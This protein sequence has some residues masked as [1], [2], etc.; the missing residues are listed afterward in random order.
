MKIQKRK[1]A[2]IWNAVLFIF[3]IAGLVI[4]LLGMGIGEMF[5]YYTQDSNIFSMCVSG[6]YLLF[7]NKDIPGW[8]NRLRYAASVS[9]M[10]TFTVVVFVL[11]PMYGVVWYPW[12]FF[13]GANFFYHLSCPLLSFISFVLFEGGEKP[14]VPDTLI[15]IIPT[16]L[17][18]V[19]LIIFNVINAVHGPYPFLY[20]HEQP[21]YMSIIWG[22]TIPGIAW[23]L[24][25]VIRSLK[26]RM[27]GADCSM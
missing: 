5:S 18:A 1:A 2:Y 19:V 14:A 11:G 21:V 17:Y 15:A 25:F 27:R 7:W 13:H 16:L 8:L 6:I 22:I 23:A 20:V 10:L 24:A 4:T 12:L 26:G 9:L 3:G